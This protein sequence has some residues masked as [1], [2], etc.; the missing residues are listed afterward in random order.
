M[1]EHSLATQ[2]GVEG[3]F[4]ADWMVGGLNGISSAL[5]TQELAGIGKILLLGSALTGCVVISENGKPRV[6]QELPALR[7]G[8]HR[9]H[10]GGH[11][12]RADLAGTQVGS[13]WR[14]WPANGM[15][16]YKLT[17]EK[18][19]DVSQDDL[20]ELAALLEE[21]TGSKKKP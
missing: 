13:E 20:D 16:Q 6:K 8:G 7:H 18:I 14:R 15:A 4:V 19:A 21:D 12:A 17:S 5:S 2:R 9:C 3:L 1:V 11:H 10:P